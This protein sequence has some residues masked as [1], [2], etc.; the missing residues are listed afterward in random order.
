MRPWCAVGS[1]VLALTLCAVGG[2]AKREWV[3]RHGA[4][5][6]YGEAPA[7]AAPAAAFVDTL[8]ARAASRRA[9]AD[10][11]SVGGSALPLPATRVGT[12]L[13]WEEPARFAPTAPPAADCGRAP[14]HWVQVA[15]RVDSSGCSS[16]LWLASVAAGDPGAARARGEVRR[17]AGLW[18]VQIGPY[19]RWEQAEAVRNRLRA[20]G[21][22]AAWLVRR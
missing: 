4:A 15:A 14:C 1:A 10:P 9:A 18:K 5:E 17:E 12:E 13:P 3:A 21:Y 2:C 6:A 7:T 8:P 16:L 22:G 19:A 20:G 11:V